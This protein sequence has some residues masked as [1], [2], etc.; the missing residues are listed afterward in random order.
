MDI[1]WSASNHY[2][3][4][5]TCCSLTILLR[6]LVISSMSFNPAV[7][8]FKTDRIKAG[9]VYQFFTLPP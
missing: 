2:K 4:R 7:I 1:K 6:S 5:V 9:S 8:F 3:R